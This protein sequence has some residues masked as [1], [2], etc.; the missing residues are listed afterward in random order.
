MR[1]LMST[2]CEVITSEA[3]RRTEM[4]SYEDEAIIFKACILF[5]QNLFKIYYYARKKA[6]IINN[7]K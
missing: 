7:N 4:A 5:K 3:R 6:Q 2:E 1:K